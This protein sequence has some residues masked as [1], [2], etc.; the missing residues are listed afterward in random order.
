MKLYPNDTLYCQN[1]YAE[2][3]FFINKG[4]I[5]MYFDLNDSIEGAPPVNIPFN[6]YVEGSYFGDSDLFVNEG[7]NVRDCTAISR[8]DSWLLVITRREL[9]NILHRFPKIK[10]EMQ[11]VSQERR[12][13]HETSMKEAA[14]RYYKEQ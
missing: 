10:K 14:E 5:K 13:Y 3:L 9:F 4:R 11:L 6:L 7:F 1:D 12:L 8:H 2:E